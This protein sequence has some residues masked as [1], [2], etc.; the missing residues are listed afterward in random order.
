MNCRWCNKKIGKGLTQETHSCRS[1]KLSEKTSSIQDVVIEKVN[2]G[3]SLLYIAN[4][5]VEFFGQ[6]ITRNNIVDICKWHN[7]TTPSLSKSAKSAATRALYKSTVMERYG[8]DNVSGA[9]IVKD[10]KEQTN[11]NRHGVNNPFQREEIKE[12]SKSTML[13]KY[14]VTN[15]IHM[16]RA[17]KMQGRLSKPH[18]KVSDAL[19]E[20]KIEH[21]N[22]QP[23]LFPKFN[24]EKNRNYGPIP[25]IFIPDKNIVVEIFGDYWHMNPIFYKATDVVKFFQG[26]RSGKDTWE[27]DR[28]RIQHIK[29]FN[30]KVLVIWEHDIKNSFE[31]TIKRII[32]F[33]E[34]N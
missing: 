27:N 26:Y 6:T 31:N 18:K 17:G 3:Y 14:G 12:K 32:E 1:K 7:V 4:N 19:L 34:E 28:K 15:P 2:E 20:N 16:P 9:Q 25:D 24:K 10:K 29:L 13:R 22:D 8:V 11:I 23:G 5:S 33:Y 30:T 21:T